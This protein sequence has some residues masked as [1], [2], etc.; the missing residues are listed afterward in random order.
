MVLEILRK[1]S[2]GNEGQ[3]DIG[4][5]KSGNI[6][7]ENHYV[8]N[9]ICALQLFVRMRRNKLQVKKQVSQRVGAGAMCRSTDWAEEMK[10]KQDVWGTGESRL[11]RV[12]CL[13]KGP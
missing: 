2:L 7:P 9:P 4:K 5:M 6:I 11:Q 1:H 8:P 10:R 12:H 13:R 3:R